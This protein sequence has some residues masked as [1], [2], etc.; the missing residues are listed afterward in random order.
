MVAVTGAVVAFV[1]TKLPMFPVPLAARPMLAV[2]FVQLYTM[3]PPVVGLLKAT[4]VVGAPLHTTWFATAVTV[5]VGLT[6]IVNVDAVPT[7]LTLPFVY[8]GVTI[9]VAVT[10][11][12]V[13]FVPTKLAMLPVPLAARPMLVVLFVQLYTMVPPVVGL[14]KFT[15]VVLAPLHTTWFVTGVTVAVG[16]TVIVNVFGVPVQLVVVPP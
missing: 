15:A 14:L 12:V 2:L 1:P 7:Q 5:A 11:A 6:V 10:G 8:V 3:V 16:F 13:A 4:A 9:I